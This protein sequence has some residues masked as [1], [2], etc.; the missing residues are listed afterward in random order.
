MVISMGFQL[1][2]N[3]FCKLARKDLE[4]SND[5]FHKNQTTVSTHTTAAKPLEGVSKTKVKTY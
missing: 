5:N 4:M 1:V 2:L 3:W